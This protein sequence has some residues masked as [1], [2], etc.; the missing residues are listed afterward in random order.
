A[1]VG[2]HWAT[3]SHGRISS[4]DN[5]CLPTAKLTATWTCKKLKSLA[6]IKVAPLRA[7]WARL[8]SSPYVA[9]DIGRSGVVQDPS[10]RP[11]A[12]YVGRWRTKGAGLRRYRA[13]GQPRLR[14][15][16]GVCLEPGGRLRPASGLRCRSWGGG[17]VFVP[18]GRSFHERQ[19][20]ART[21]VS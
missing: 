16:A 11:V 7:R 9:A 19:G 12:N 17:G 20:E 5:A 4:A 21:D 18:S 3:L 8:K 10:K 2:E 14:N 15:P 6:V 13:A 1:S